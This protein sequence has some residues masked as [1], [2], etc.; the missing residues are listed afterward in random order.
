M[1]ALIPVVD[2][3][4]DLPWALRRRFDYDLEACDIAAHQPLLNTDLPR[5]AEGGVRAQF[6]SVFVPGAPRDASLGAYAVD[7]LEQIDCVHRLLAQHPDRLRLATTADEL[8]AACEDPSA[9][10]ASLMG[11][12]GAHSIHGSIG[13]LRMLHRLGVRYMTL[14]H[15][16]N[17]ECADAATDEPVHGG[18][19]D[20]GR[21]V[22]AEMNRL[23]MMVDLSHVSVD[24]M[25]DALATTSAPVIFSHSS[26]RAVVDHPRNVPDEI[27][28]QMAA[29]GGTCMVTFVPAFVSERVREW[30]LRRDAAAAELGLVWTDKAYADFYVAFCDTDPRP[31]ATLD[32]VIAHVE[33]VREVA[34]IDHIG[35]GGDY[36]GADDFP[37]GLEDVAGYPRLFA[38]LAERGWSRAD[39]EK[40]GWRNIAATMRRV[41]ECARP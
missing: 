21:E 26:A 25:R 39:L 30:S 3:H 20:L 18:L 11:A 12:E 28:A 35:L 38:A 15:N 27:L 16:E 14:T 13:A 36:D 32:D 22:V 23:G 10:I 37:E 31:S 33:H 7:T 17:N 34:G 40:L 1:S 8:T 5:L 6:W 24:T 4:N 2:G 9:P 41:E 19:S 29:G